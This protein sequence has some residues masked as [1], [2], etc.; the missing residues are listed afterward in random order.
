MSVRS[1]TTS[2]YTPPDCDDELS[3]I[4][5]DSPDAV[6]CCI[7]NVDPD[8]P[9]ECE[10]QPCHKDDNDCDPAIG[11]GWDCEEQIG[12][13]F[14]KY[15][16]FARMNPDPAESDQDLPEHPLSD[17]SWLD[18]KRWPGYIYYVGCAKY[19]VV[20]RCNT[21]T[22]SD[23]DWYSCTN[24]TISNAE[25]GFRLHEYPYSTGYIPDISGNQD[26]AHLPLANHYTN[27]PSSIAGRI[28]STNTISSEE[29]GYL[30]YVENGNYKIKECCNSSVE[31]DTLKGYCN[32]QISFTAGLGD[33]EEYFLPTSG[34]AGAP[35]T[36]YCTSDYTWSVDLDVYERTCNVVHASDGAIGWTGSYCCG[37]NDDNP[38]Y[39]NDPGPNSPGACWNGTFQESGNYVQYPKDPPGENYGNIFVVN[40][41]FHGCMITDP[42]LTSL[43]HCPAHPNSQCTNDPLFTWDFDLNRFNSHSAGETLTDVELYCDAVTGEW[44]DSFGVIWHQSSI[45]P[46]L[47]AEP[48]HYNPDDNC[49][50]WWTEEGTC[51]SD[52]C[53]MGCDCVNS[54]T[55][56]QDPIS[57]TNYRCINGDWVESKIKY[58]WDRYSYGY[59]PREDQCLVNP[60]GNPDTYDVTDYEYTTLKRDYATQGIYGGLDEWYVD[61]NDQSPICIDNDQYIGD[62]YCENG[63]WSSRTKYVAT[64]L[65]N[66]AS[67]TEDY[68]LFCD[69]YWRALNKYKDISLPTG[70]LEMYLEQQCKNPDVRDDPILCTN[71]ICVLK[72]Y[73]YRHGEHII[74]G[75]TLNAPINTPTARSP[76]HKNF[77]EVLGIDDPTICD[78]AM[79]TTTFTRCTGASDLVYY[80]DKYTSLIFSNKEI[81][82]LPTVLPPDPESWLDYF[83]S[84]IKLP[85]ESIINY[86]LGTVIM[87]PSGAGAIPLDFIFDTTRFDRIFIDV[88]PDG[89]VITAINEKVRYYEDEYVY[90]E[91]MAIN[92]YGFTVNICDSLNQFS[93]Y[94]QSEGYRYDRYS[95]SDYNELNCSI[96]SD[97]S[98]YVI[99]RRPVGVAVG[100]EVN[101]YGDGYKW[102][103]EDIWDDLTEQLRVQ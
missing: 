96:G 36:Y 53:W 71:K 10:F 43:Q 35:A 17:W 66:Y 62:N 61:K 54:F 33:S 91:Y 44:M 12:E 2:L 92:Y 73:D 8:W 86:L 63:V 52:R 51:E 64:Q 69:N 3:C 90:D 97:D 23:S 1:A 27:N 77:L 25:S 57:P 78:N 75:V 76:A 98:Y 26:P 59:C 40:G 50:S 87:Y 20:S 34:S 70:D 103:G 72:Y 24:Y 60:G 9:C 19:P 13:P 18:P 4:T 49:P 95:G 101:Y 14:N 38:E 28:P 42:L 79:G 21:Q 93:Q 47:E 100:F 46:L 16:P 83:I 6:D 22:C 81:E 67:S 58:T 56:Q 88:K 11:Y 15:P 55:I 32:S 80:N 94:H 68:T 84:L 29:H 89:K 99:S 102:I 65:L 39:Y 5:C 37:D 74:F 45:L 31:D 85:I 82:L 7:C 41:T 48:E 30:C